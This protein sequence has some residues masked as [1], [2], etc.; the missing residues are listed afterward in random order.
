MSRIGVLIKIVYNLYVNGEENRLL[1]FYL[2]YFDAT[3][4]FYPSYKILSKLIVKR[5]QEDSVGLMSKMQAG[6]MDKMWGMLSS[7]HI[8]S[9]HNP[10][11]YS[12]VC[13]NLL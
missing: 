9:F 10:D 4:F 1:V 7:D 11:L 5:S 6:Q 3:D 8:T 2:D 12:I 13:I